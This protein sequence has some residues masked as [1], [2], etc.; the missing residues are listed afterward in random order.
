MMCPPDARKAESPR[1]T[2]GSDLKDMLRWALVAAGI[3][4]VFGIVLNVLEA[5]L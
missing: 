5:V 1:T 2:L 3:T 4:A